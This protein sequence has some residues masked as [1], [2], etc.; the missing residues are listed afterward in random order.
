MDPLVKRQIVILGSGWGGIHTYLELHRQFHGHAN[1]PAVTIISPTDYFLYNLLLHEVATGG[2]R[3]TSLMHYI[4][5]IGGCSCGLMKQIVKGDATAVDISRQVVMTTAGEIAYDYVVVS[6][7]AVTRLF[8]FD[9]NLVYTLKD[10]AQ[11][12]KLKARIVEMFAQAAAAEDSPARQRLLTF[13][14]VGGGPTGVELACEISQFGRETLLP[15]YRNIKREE[16]SVVLIQS[17][18]E[19]VPMFKQFVR[20]HTLARAKKTPNLKLIMNAR[21]EQI[22]DSQVTLSSGEII[23]TATVVLVAGVQARQMKFIPEIPLT[24]TGQVEANG[25]LQLPSA[26]NVFVIGDMASVKQAEGF[27]PQTAQAAKYEGWHA[28]KNIKALMQGRPLKSFV[29]KEL[30]QVVSLGRWHAAGQVLKIYGFGPIMWLVW[31]GIDAY[32]FLTWNNL[33]A[34]LGDWLKDIFHGKSP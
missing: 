5:A 18:N 32:N 26:P 10:V 9:P 20:R 22:T 17:G 24:K 2:V 25:F 27:V 4:R 19:L 31:R 1:A 12:E 28:A 6:I 7:G 16:F 8:N 3:A 15:K 23:P 13:A 30:A 29:Y 11:A 21:A 14:V 34:V 33:K